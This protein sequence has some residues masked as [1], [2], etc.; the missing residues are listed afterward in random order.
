MFGKLTNS[1]RVDHDSDLSNSPAHHKCANGQ[2]LLNSSTENNKS[3]NIERNGNVTGPVNDGVGLFRI[4]RTD[5]TRTHQRRNSASKTPLFLRM[6][7][8]MTQSLKYRPRTSPMRTATCHGMSNQIIRS[9]IE[10]SEHVQW[11]F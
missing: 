5:T 4:Q 10:R 6:Q 3:A 9:N 7:K 11:V 1:D 2:V 8:F